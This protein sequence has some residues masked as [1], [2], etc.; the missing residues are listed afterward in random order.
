MK[1]AL[2]EGTPDAGHVTFSASSP[3]SPRKKQQTDHLDLKTAHIADPSRAPDQV[4]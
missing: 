2:N 4:E 1:K 3:H